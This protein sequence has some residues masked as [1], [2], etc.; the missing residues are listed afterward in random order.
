MSLLCGT[1]IG[2]KPVWSD[3]DEFTQ[4]YVVCAFWQ[5]DPCP[6][7]GEYVFDNA[8]WDDLDLND[9]L[10]IIRDCLKF[11]LDSNHLLQAAYLTKFYNKSPHYEPAECAGHD[12][13][14]SRNGH[15]VGFRDRGNDPLW[16]KLH[17]AARNCGEAELH[18]WPDAPGCK[19]WEETGE[20]DR[21]CAHGGSYSYGM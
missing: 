18:Y 9:Q 16:E 20:C 5:A 2:D 3:L 7:S 6:G 4:G 8:L 11:Q 1:V 14:L 17:E 10:T 15:G 19:H 13:Y 12:F 21:D